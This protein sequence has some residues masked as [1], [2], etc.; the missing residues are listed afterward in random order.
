[1]NSISIA[2]NG[3]VVG[4]TITG[5]TGGALSP[6]AGNWNLLG[7]GSITTSGAGSTL[8]TQLTGLTNHA[9]LVGAGTA[10]ITKLALG[11]AGQ[12]LQ[13]GGA[14]ADPAYSTP[15]YPSASGS[16]GKILISDGTNN[17]YS[18][19]TYPNASVTA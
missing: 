3:A 4:Q 19:P 12:V 10:T 17:I 15:T 6:T 1:S 2:A 14:G 9:I 13:S 11:S 8:T 7:S 18:T 16:S 5:D